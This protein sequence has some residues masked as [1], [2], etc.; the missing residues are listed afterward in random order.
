M[1]ITTIGADLAKS[2]FQIFIANQAGRLLT[3]RRFSRA[4]FDQFLATHPPANIV[5]ETCA[6]AHYALFAKV[7]TKRWVGFNTLLGALHSTV[8]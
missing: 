2:V 6:T 1:H 7:V 5:M 3:R 4:Q 8:T